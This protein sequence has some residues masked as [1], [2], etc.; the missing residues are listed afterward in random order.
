MSCVRMTWVV[1]TC[2]GFQMTAA[3]VEV[4]EEVVAGAEAEVE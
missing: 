1:C 3:V 2:Q 4:V